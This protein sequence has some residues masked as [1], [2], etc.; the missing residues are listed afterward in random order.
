MASLLTFSYLLKAEEKQEGLKYKKCGNHD[1]QEFCKGVLERF[2]VDKDGQLSEDE[3]AAA[4][5]A[6]EEKVRAKM[7]EKFTERF[8]EIDSDNNGCISLEEWIAFHQK[9][10]EEWK[11]KMP[12]A[13]KWCRRNGKGNNGVGNG[14]DPAPHGNPTENDGPDTSPG[15][16]GN[17]SGN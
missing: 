15:N 1:N 3:I 10:M 11:K 4:R 12:P 13:G 5:I 17:K 14:E 7:T 16:P 2:D 6:R 9:R 8:K